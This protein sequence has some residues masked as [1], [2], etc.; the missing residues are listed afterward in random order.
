M[1]KRPIVCYLTFILALMWSQ[2]GGLWAQAPFLNP[3]KLGLPEGLP[4]QLINSIAQDQ[5]GFVW[6]ATNDGLCRYDGSRLEV[7]NLVPND[8]SAAYTRSVNHILVEQ[9]Q[10]RLWLSTNLG[11]HRLDPLNGRVVSYRSGT[12]GGLV[13][14]RCDFTYQ[15][16]QGRLWIG[17]YNGGLLQYLPETERFEPVTLSDYLPPD[18]PGL[19]VGH[20]VIIRMAQNLEDEDSYWLLTRSGLAHWERER[21]KLRFWPLPPPPGRRADELMAP[22]SFYQ[23]ANGDLLIGFWSDGILRFQARGSKWEWLEEAIHSG[24]RLSLGSCYEFV[25]AG[26]QEVWASFSNNTVVKLSWQGSFHTAAAWEGKTR[27]GQSYGVRLIDR[28]GNLWAGYRQGVGLYYPQAQQVEHHILIPEND[29]FAYWP[30]GLASLPGGNLLA[31][32]GNAGGLYEL[33][34]ASGAFRAVP[35]SAGDRQVLYHSQGMIQTRQ[36]DILLWTNTDLYRYDP[37]G[38]AMHKLRPTSAWQGARFTQ[39]REDSRGDL[40]LGTYNLGLFRY[41]RGQKAW[42]HYGEEIERGGPNHSAWLWGFTEDQYGKIWLRGSTGYS[43]YYP[44]RDSFANFPF[45]EGADNN[46]SSIRAFERGRGGQFWALG[47]DFGLGLIDAQRPEAGIVQFLEAS[48]MGRP[49][50]YRQMAADGQGNLWLVSSQGLSRV[51]AANQNFAHYDQ[52]CGLPGY[53]ALLELNSMDNARLHLLPDGHFALQYRRGIALFHPDS[54]PQVHPLPRPYVQRVKVFEEPLTLDSLGYFR[55]TL[56]LKAGSN[57]F[58][59]EFSALQFSAPEGTR[60]RYRLKGLEENW[61]DAGTRRYAAYTNVPGGRYV[62]QLMAANSSG[63]WNAEPYELHI[64]LAKTL[65]EQ[66]WFQLLIVT[67]LLSAGYGFY[68]WR[69]QQLRQRQRE[70]E[71]FAKRL[72]DMEMNALRAQMNPHFIFNCLNSIDS[73]IIKN[74]THKASAYLNDFARLIRLMLQN[75]RNNLVSLQDELEALELYLQMEQLRFSQKFQYHLQVSADIPLAAAYIPPLL[76]QPYVE[77]A[78]WHGL[79]H[80][81]NGEMGKVTVLIKPQGTALHITITD[82]GVGRVKAAELKARRKTAHKPA[83][84]TQ[85]TAD[86]IE[87]I[88]QMYQTRATVNS[89]DLMDSEGRPAGTQVVLLIPI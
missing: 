30:N 58:S 85:I 56:K 40:W 13:N 9:N 32:F 88:N 26:E 19:P 70:R 61:V 41:E 72:A 48:Q 22:R 64:H 66:L 87:L 4:N 76:I 27:G 43:V 17:N 36:G 81:Q 33:Y 15:D 89:F 80:K 52:G 46:L 60:F 14:Q 69:I 24:K 21:G 44:E 2:A 71:E 54:L 16:R 1:L 38:R 67:L 83:M 63:E 78:I 62:L 68:R 84:G 10:D 51:D 28:D 50:H 25:P 37:P 82:N 74:E 29:T 53:D 77:N 57:Y 75:S 11:L 3:R 47:S 12:P 65:R 8:S 55:R 5:A 86:R 49:A 79:L 42:R 31:L 45:R 34:P 23:H 59:F 18:S 7:L 73:F 6:I 39:V 20:E 35:L